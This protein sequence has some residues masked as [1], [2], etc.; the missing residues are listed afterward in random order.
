MIQNNTMNSD[1]FNVLQNFIL[2]EQ[3]EL[4][5]GELKSDSGLVL[6]TEQNTSVVDRPTTGTV[7]KV[8]PQV[9]NV[10][11]NSEVL[12]P[13]QDGLEIQFKNGIFMLLKETSI[14]GFKA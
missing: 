4:E 14:L 2:V 6:A 9:E 10:P 12:W 5:T 3:V 8:G 13:E 1:E 7:L 11:V